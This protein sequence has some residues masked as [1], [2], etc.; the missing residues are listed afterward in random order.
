MALAAELRNNHHVIKQLLAGLQ[1]AAA[2][3]EPGL[4]GPLQ[5]LTWGAQYV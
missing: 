2:A 1:S 3:L 5:Q 4:L